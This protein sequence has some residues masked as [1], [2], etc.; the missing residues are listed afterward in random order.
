MSQP[1]NVY[2]I[3]DLTVATDEAL[4]GVF[5]RLGYTQNYRLIDTKLIIGYLI[6]FIAAISFLLDRKVKW[7]DALF[8]QKVLVASYLMLSVAFWFVVE[9]MEN[10]IKYQGIKDGCQ[11]TVKTK[12]EKFNPICKVVLIEESGTKLE[13]ELPATK[14]F[15]E[16]GALQF[17]LL[18]KWFE[19]QIRVLGDKKRK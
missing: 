6:S 11:L 15:S 16:S 7:H 19:D 17:N 9:Y 14:V 2:S 10:G 5:A 18:L 3:P 13:V 1:I 12:Y 4:P 8:Y